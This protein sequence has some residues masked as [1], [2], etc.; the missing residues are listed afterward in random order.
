[1][2]RNQQAFTLLEIIIVVSVIGLLAIIAVPRFIK[3]RGGAQKS[4]CVNNLRQIDSAKTMHAMAAQKQ[5][6]DSVEPTSLTP[7]LKKPFENIIEPASGEYQIREVGEIP[8]CT[9]GGEHALPGTE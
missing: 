6:G 4:A 2:K 5:S 8:I 7:Y 9:V 1:M 3:A